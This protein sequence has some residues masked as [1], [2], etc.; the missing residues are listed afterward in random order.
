MELN[1]PELEGQGNCET[2]Y[3]WPSFRVVPCHVGLASLSCQ[4]LSCQ[5]LLP[6]QFFYVRTYQP[7]FHVVPC[8]VELLPCR[9]K[10]CRVIIFP[11]FRA[12]PCWDHSCYVCHTIDRE[13]RVHAIE[14]VCS[15]WLFP[16][17]G[18]ATTLRSSVTVLVCIFVSCVN[19][20]IVV[21]CWYVLYKNLFCFRATII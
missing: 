13:R 11:C 14:Y 9:V 5:R 20:Q 15:S 7:S 19:C 12:V 17:S 16:N 8:R 1:F 10:P 4:E 6:S 21:E 18:I 3:S 2:L